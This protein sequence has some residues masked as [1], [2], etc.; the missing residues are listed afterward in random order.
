[1]Q[2]S[3]KELL[4]AGG[5]ILLILAAIS[6]YSLALVFER[7]GYFKKHAGNAE[8]LGKEAAR[9]AKTGDM[10]KA[11]D[12][13]RRAKN[14]T[15]DALLQ[16]MASEGS[17]EE[18]RAY[19][20][21]VIS[22]QS[23]QL[24]KGLSFLAT[25]GSTAPFIGLFGTVLGVMRAFR[26]LA[27][28]SGAGPSVVA[29]GISEALVNTAAGLFV[30]IPAIFAYNYFVS[31]TNVFAK[32]IEWAGEEIIAAG[33]AAPAATEPPHYPKPQPPAPEALRA[34]AIARRPQ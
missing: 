14:L 8:Q 25:I 21:A 23:A 1:M 20:A 12:A 24:H 10:K 30:A 4:F 9:L 32:E 22:H 18:R 29:A 5:P 11:I 26:D 3:L 7:W 33:I 16:I 6:I 19:V 2:F 27:S 15:G 34:P 13:A 28:Y 31:K 17:P